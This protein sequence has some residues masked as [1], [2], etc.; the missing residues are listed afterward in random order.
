MAKK[1]KP[2]IAPRRPPP[3]VTPA[4]LEDFIQGKDIGALPP[5]AEVSRPPPALAKA[6]GRPQTAME[7]VESPA[8]P[9]LPPHQAAM[10]A[11]EP[12]APPALLPPQ[13]VQKPPAEALPADTVSRHPETSLDDLERP[14]TSGRPRGLVERE[15]GR[16]RRRRTVY[17]PPEL[18]ERL[19]RWC[20]D[21]GRE[22]SHAVAE[23]IRRMLDER[24]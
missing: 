22:V 23:A 12:P 24:P 17:L 2:F 1:P 14:Q 21:Q 6:P 3:A 16:L 8:H 10:E 5:T 20:T 11:V 18:D 9:V 13:A 7:A 4:E 15:G 19:D